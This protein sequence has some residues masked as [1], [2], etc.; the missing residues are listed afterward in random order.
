[1]NHCDCKTKTRAGKA[2][3]L[4]IIDSHKVIV[5]VP[6]T[7]VMTKRYTRGQWNANFEARFYAW[8]HKKNRGIW[9]PTYFARLQQRFSP[10]NDDDFLVK[11][12]FSLVSVF[13]TSH[14][15]C[16][17]I[18]KWSGETSIKK[19]LV[20]VIILND[21]CRKWKLQFYLNSQIFRLSKITSNRLAIME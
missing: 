9:Y 21:N 12:Q 15:N 8:K 2:P 10:L 17:V 13:E 16:F 14:L 4:K 18:N 19:I 6:P 1:M 5:Q 3:I 7:F 11:V 20:L